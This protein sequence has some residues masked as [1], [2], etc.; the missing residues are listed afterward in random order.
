MMS[1]HCLRCSAL[2]VLTGLVFTGSAIGDGIEVKITPS[3]YASFGLG[4]IVRSGGADNY[5]GNFYEIQGQGVQTDHL[6]M[7]RTFVGFNLETSFN[8][9]P[10]TTNIGAEMESFNETPRDA[11]EYGALMRNYFYPY[12][13]RADVTYMYSKAFNLDIGY[14]PFKYNSDSRNLG[15]YLFRTGTYPQYI[16]T[17]FDFPLARLAGLLLNGTPFQGFTYDAILNMNT[18]WMTMGNLNFTGIVSYKPV[19]VFEI[20]AGIQFANF[21]VANQNFTHP[22]NGVQLADQYLISPG[23]TGTYTFVGTKAMARVSL[24]GKELFPNEL[25][26]MF[27]DNDLRIYSEA[28][29]L[30]L[31]NYPQSIGINSQM[32]N[33]PVTDYSD[34]AKRIPVMFGLNFPVFKLLDVLSLEGEWFGSDRPNSTDGLSAIDAPDNEVL[35]GGNSSTYPYNDSTKD[36]WKWSVYA[37]KTIASHLNVTGQVACDHYRWELY[38][39]SDQVQYAGTEVFREP[40]R[41]YYIIK[42]GYNF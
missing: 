26:S 15:E 7:Q 34:M 20:G 29:I 37:K 28:A 30:G 24:D 8:L 39:F 40:N 38:N 13:T 2:S 32:N 10:I 19:K 31:K 11:A 5:L 27:G 3:G 36:H 16:I 12:I 6:L 41:F 33:A 4:Q 17:N 21:L 22:V 35:S 23:D 14:F 18:D 25:K 42:L 1:K 9:L